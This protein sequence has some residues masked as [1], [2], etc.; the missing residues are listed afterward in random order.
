MTVAEGRVTT[1]PA[2]PAPSWAGA[3]GPAEAP[4]LADG[5]ELLGV[6]DGAHHRLDRARPVPRLVANPRS[7]LPQPPPLCQGRRCANRRR[8]SRGT[9]TALRP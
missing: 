1:G 6:R 7:A 2:A 5:V 3:S 4:R 9:P 8:F